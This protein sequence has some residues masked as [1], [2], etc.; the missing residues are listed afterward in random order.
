MLIKEKFYIQ[1]SRKCYFFSGRVILSELSGLC[2]L[3]KWERVILS[4]AFILSGRVIL[5]GTFILS[6]RKCCTDQSRA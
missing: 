4:V 1:I 5:S 2:Y 6:E 3:I